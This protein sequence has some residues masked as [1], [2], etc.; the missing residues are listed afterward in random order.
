MDASLLA[1]NDVIMA[2]LREVAENVAGAQHMATTLAT[3]LAMAEQHWFEIQAAIPGFGKCKKIKSH[4]LVSRP[5]IHNISVFS[6]HGVAPP[7]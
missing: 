3:P 4:N 2:L 7:C 6:R 1:D 5:I